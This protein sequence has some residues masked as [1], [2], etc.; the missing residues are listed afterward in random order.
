MKFLY[1]NFLQFYLL[2]LTSITQLSFIYLTKNT[3]NI[4]YFRIIIYFCLISKKYHY[5][6]W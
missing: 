5:Y 2:A 6:L 1:E 3:S 4:S